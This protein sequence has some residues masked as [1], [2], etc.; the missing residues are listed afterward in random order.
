MTDT[1][2]T[3]LSVENWMVFTLGAGL[4][5][6]K[7]VI[8]A[9][10]GFL[11][12]YFLLR[13]FKDSGYRRDAFS[14]KLIV[15]ALAIYVFGLVACL[16]MPTTTEDLGVIARK[17]LYLVIFA[18]LLLAFRQSSNRKFA[19]AGLLIGFWAAATMTFYFFEEIEPGRLTGATWRVDVWGLLCSL[20]FVFLMPRIFDSKNSALL[21]ILFAITALTAFILLI[22]SGARGPL[23]GACFAVGLYLLFYQRRAIGMILVI[24]ILA[25]IPIKHFAPTPLAQIE[26]RV[27][28]I[29]DTEEDISNWI[30]LKLWKL[31]FAH[32][33]EKFTMNPSELLL[34]SGAMSHFEKVYG[35]F[36][37]TDALTPAEKNRLSAPDV[38]YPTNDMHNMYLDA[39]AKYGLIWTLAHILFLLAIAT[40][41]MRQTTQP[42]TSG[43][44]VPLLVV[45]FLLIGIFYTLLPHFAGTFLI[46]F[47]ALALRSNETQP[48]ESTSVS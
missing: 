20:F 1:K 13:C 35:F 3:A 25:Y 38:G 26:Q 27:A 39:V 15:A 19:L 32:S 23:L 31:S 42:N 30:R 48:V 43:L 2:T 4:F 10:T 37:R 8:Y 44:A 17:S 9:A 6:S 24:A 46:F 14:N 21:R 36:E 5:L 47:L 11:T 22:L 28:S 16:L 18:P 45:C 29:V 34:G 12:L 33:V 41:A 7:P 40:I